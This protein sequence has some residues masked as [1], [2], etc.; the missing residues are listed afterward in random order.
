EDRER[1][2]V[3]QQVDEVGVREETIVV[4]REVR[5]RQ[6]TDD[7]DA[8]LPQRQQ[9]SRQAS[10]AE[11]L[12]SGGGPAGS[13]V[14]GDGRIGHG[15]QAFVTPAAAVVPSYRVLVLL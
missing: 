12:G 14:A 10:G 4:D 7:D 2:E 9:P 15:N 3:G 1:R 6:H 8:A 13:R 11:P 5:R